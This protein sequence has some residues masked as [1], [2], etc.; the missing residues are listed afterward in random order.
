MTLTDRG[1]TASATMLLDEMGKL[2]DLVAERYCTVDGGFAL[3]RW[4]TPVNEYGE[5]A[6]RRLPV[7]GRAVWKLADGD[8]EYIDVT[9]TELRYDAGP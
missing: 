1:K 7:R 3:A 9:V 5:V 4:S 6:G 8:L 2:T